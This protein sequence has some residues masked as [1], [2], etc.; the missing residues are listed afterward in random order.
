MSMIWI[1]YSQ[2]F[3]DWMRCQA[4][5]ASVKQTELRDSLGKQAKQAKQARQARRGAL[6]Y[7]TIFRI[8]IFAFQ[9]SQFAI[10]EAYKM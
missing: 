7:Q 10:V 4:L 5:Q 6:R 1:R 2:M 9:Y 8:L 3:E